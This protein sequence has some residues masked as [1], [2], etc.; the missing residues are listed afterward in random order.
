MAKNFEKEFQ[1]LN[2]LKSHLNALNDNQRR[3]FILFTG[4]KD[5]ETNQ[6]WC[7]DCQIADPVVH[8]CF[9]DKLDDII[10]LTCY[11]GD[12]PTWKNP[13]N[14]FR[15]DREFQLKCIPTLIQ[16]KTV[17][18]IFVLLNLFTYAPHML[19]FLLLLLLVKLSKKN[20]TNS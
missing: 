19:L 3:V 14:E 7:P 12:R 17:F 11:V 2:E 20:K 4:N 10:F 8:K 18:F 13:E 16:W 6:S 9:S 5:Q 15:K 1:S